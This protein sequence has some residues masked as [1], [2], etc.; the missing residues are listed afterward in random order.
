VEEKFLAV[1]RVVSEYGKRLF[2]SI[3]DRPEIVKISKA[4][5]SD[6]SGKAISDPGICLANIVSSGIISLAGEV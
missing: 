2:I 3:S 5:Q 1:S 4:N 6:K